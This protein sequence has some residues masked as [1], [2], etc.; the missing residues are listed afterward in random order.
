MR[1]RDLCMDP[2]LTLRLAREGSE[3]P[4]GLVGVANAG[5]L[6]QLMRRGRGGHGGGA[7]PV[8]ELF[9]MARAPLSTFE[10]REQTLLEDLAHPGCGLAR[11]ALGKRAGG[12]KRVLPLH[13]L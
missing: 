3:F 6:A 4:A 5:Q 13:D 1:T 7:H 2:R 10:G 9:E 11:A 8:L 12:G